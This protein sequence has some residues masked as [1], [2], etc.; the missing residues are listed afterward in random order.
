MDNIVKIRLALKDDIPALAILSGQLGYPAS[1]EE[2]E[3]RLDAISDYFSHA[4][5]VAEINGKVV[6]WIHG[7]ARQ[8]LL[9][10]DHIEIGGLVVDE[11]HRSQKIGEQLLEAIE[12]WAEELGVE[13]VYVASNQTR[14]DAHR[15]YLAHGY[16][17]YK[18]SF[19]FRKHI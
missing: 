7:F 16:E 10:G 12:G 2:M 17:H 5:F 19:K 13:T 15:F 18:T 11:D 14:K 9:V 6:G 3:E 4:V 1:P 8:M